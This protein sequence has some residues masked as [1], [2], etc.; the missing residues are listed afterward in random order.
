MNAGK[1]HSTCSPS[2]DGLP[3][4]CKVVAVCNATSSWNCWL[5]S[6]AELVRHFG[7][8][9]TDCGRPATVT[10]EFGEIEPTAPCQVR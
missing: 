4:E 2:L 6:N 8:R 9:R 7:W 1:G 3:N 10:G 5:G